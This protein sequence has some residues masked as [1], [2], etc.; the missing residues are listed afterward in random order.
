MLTMKEKIL[1]AIKEQLQEYSLEDQAVLL[2]LLRHNW[3]K[4]LGTE[5]F[6]EY[7]SCWKCHR[8]SLI[9]EY[10]VREEVKV[11]YLTGVMPQKYMA[12]F[13]KC[14]KCGYEREKFSQFIAMHPEEMNLTKISEN[15]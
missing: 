6:A 1:N 11:R 4:E 7:A 12:K 3:L 9:S 8:F 13:I 5:I 2:M 15:L 14:P 10:E